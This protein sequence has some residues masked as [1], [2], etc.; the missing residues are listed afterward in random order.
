MPDT[1]VYA[2]NAGTKEIYVLAMNRE[3]GEL[4]LTSGDKE[5]ATLSILSVDTL[6]LR[7]S[8]HLINGVVH[9]RLHGA[10]SVAAEAACEK[11]KA[12]AGVGGAPPSVASGCAVSGDLTLQDHDVQ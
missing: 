6:A 9:R 2:S 10:S 4:T 12:G 3:S 7:N 1:V 5:Q 11:P 8:S